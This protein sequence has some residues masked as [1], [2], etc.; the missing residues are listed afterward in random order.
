MR[1]SWAWCSKLNLGNFRSI[2]QDPVVFQNTANLS[3]QRIS[4]T[5]SKL[6]VCSADIAVSTSHPAKYEFPMLFHA[7]NPIHAY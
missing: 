6:A 7:A 2:Q 1:G 4:Q 5:Y 3:R